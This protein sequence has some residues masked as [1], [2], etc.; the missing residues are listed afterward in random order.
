[1]FGPRFQVDSVALASIDLLCGEGAQ[2]DEAVDD[3]QRSK[4]AGAG[5]TVGAHCEAASL[6]AEGL[7][8]RSEMARA[9]EEERWAELGLSVVGIIYHRGSFLF[10]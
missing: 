7:R 6:A 5:A 4:G 1:M 3:L 9:A 2:I 8:L 10:G